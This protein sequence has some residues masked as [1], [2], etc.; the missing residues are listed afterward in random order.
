MTLRRKT[1]I[2]IGLTLVGLITVLYT[3]LSTITL[4]RFAALEDENVRQNVRRAADAMSDSAD[5]M[6]VMAGDY[7]HWDDTYNF[8]KDHNE[9]YVDINF[10]DSTFAGLEINMAALIDSSG[11]IVYSS[12][13][14]LDT[15]KQ[16]P[17]PEGLAKHLAPN[18][19]LLRHPNETHKV[20]GIVML[21]KGPMV[22]ASHPIVTSESKGP[23]RG[24][25]IM[26]RFLDSSEVRRL[27]KVTHLN[28]IARPFHSKKADDDV[29]IARL[30]L[31]GKDGV[32]VQPL[33]ANS[34]AGYT[35]I[36]DVYGKPAILLR[37]HTSRS[38]YQQ[39]RSSAHYFLL[40]SLVIGIIFG[41]VTL[42]L[43]ERL[44]LSRLAHLS[45]DVS[46]IGVSGDLSARVF[47]AGRDELSRLAD[48]IS[49]TLEALESL[50][51]E[52]RESEERLK[53]IFDSVKA[54]VI[55]IDAET[56]QIVDAN[57]LA[58]ETIGAS[59]NEIIGSTC[60]KF[61]CPMNS[62]DCPVTDHHQNVDH[63]ECALLTA[64]GSSVPI[65]KTV[66]PVTLNGRKCLL[67][68]FVDIS[69]LKK[70]ED[71]LRKAHDELETRV[72]AR[73]AEL[74]KA[75]KTLKEEIAE[76]KQAEADLHI[77][78]SAIN[79][80]SDQIVI[81]DAQGNIEF[82]NPSFE[83]ETGYTIEEVI[84]KNPRI[85]QSGKHTVDFYSGLWNTILAGE[86]WHSEMTNRRK[87]GNIST[88][89]VTITPVKDKT[90]TIIHFIAIKRNITEKK[91]YEKRLNHL[92]HHDHLTGLPNRLLFADR[93][94][95]SLAQAKRQ[96][97]LLAVMF[98]DLDRFKNINDTLGHSVGDLLLK[99]VA[100]RLEKCVR[101]VD[102]LARMG[103]DEFTITLANI[104]TAQDA[105]II[106]KRA[107]K[108]LSDPFV[109]GG[110]E[111]FITAS[112]GISLYPSD[113]SDV[114]TLVKNA[115]TAMYRAKDEGRNN[116]QFYTDALN[117]QAFERMEMEN[118]LRKAV[119]MDELRVYYQP[120]VDVRTGEILGVEALVR[121]QHP[122][123]GLVPPMQFI[124]L[125]EE[126]GLI[127]PISEW[128]LRTSCRQNKVWQDA[129]FPMMTVAVNIS[130]R[131]LHQEDLIG[132]VERVL[133]ETGL[134]AKY[135][136]LELTESTLMQNPA[137]ATTILGVL[138]SKGV[139]ISID[140]FGTG[141]SSLSYLKRF[142]TDAVK[143]DQSFIREIATNSD[144]AAIAKA[145]VAMAHSLKLKV[146]AEGVETLEQLQFLRSL[147]C[148]EIQGYFIS[149]PEPADSIERLLIANRQ[150][151][152]DNLSNAA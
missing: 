18:S 114:K 9:R 31:T 132:T 75:N 151:N 12:G 139:R 127:T 83:K 41:G 22:V 45:E 54:G 4:R 43:L 47:L 133:S 40:W 33:S 63:K 79:A 142:P 26:G 73:T 51:I 61:I 122:K 146:V 123:L 3:T 117:A 108:A 53:T 112:I 138:R 42:L 115:D 17:L 98:L 99:A 130:A 70:A 144:D 30:K 6:A 109:L 67:E 105:A 49:G 71:A 135:L 60:H 78:S 69:E 64:N 10:T 77:Q 39:G 107:L 44:V 57:P 118:D 52:L 95:Q 66:V 15:D 2:T 14:D 81:T 91:T 50:Q 121:W 62:G 35:V 7:A 24:S 16:T 87:D 5:K 110:R 21:S 136:E 11:R 152:Q 85:L 125:A 58:V 32:F 147:K 111:M 89:D 88:D 96:N 128:V 37:V 149:R 34:I 76:R 29:L 25:L 46:R 55:I 27:A 65:V 120:R 80:T 141:Y 28:L 68:S 145:I 23:V 104:L 131:L 90:G 72:Q 101:D 93:L 129:A 124:P 148:D 86:T 126:T 56:H 1:I 97:S 106:A 19:P 48:S 150:A 84:G 137:L 100:E 8:I 102:A 20:T 119:E 113:G 36:K 116:C 134:D 59:K 13:F 103:G 140:D 38:V 92:A 143:I 74:A 82:V 94:T